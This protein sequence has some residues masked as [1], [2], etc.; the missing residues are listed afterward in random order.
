M[1]R[2]DYV[3]IGAGSAGSVLANRLTEDGQHRVL[4]LEA[5]GRDWHPY[6]HLP[7]GYGRVYYDERI[8]WKFLTA[9]VPGLGG[10]PSYWPRGKVLGGSSSINGMV[11][12]RGHPGD[13]ED[14]AEVAPGWGW[15][16]VEPAFR[17]LERWSGPPSQARGSH[18]P[19]PVSNIT[20]EVHETCRNFL[21]ASRE[22]G[23][24]E[25]ADHNGTELEGTSVYQMTTLG[26]LRASAARC[27]L[28]PAKGRKT[29]EIRT[30]AHVCGLVFE[31]NRAVGVRYRQGGHEAEVRA[32][33]SV[34]LSAGAVGS[35]QILQLSGLGPAAVL[36][37]HG[38]PLRREMPHIGQHLQDHL[39]VDY[40]YRSRVPT[41][42]QRL[43]PWIGRIAAALRFAT[44]RRGPL[45]IGVNHAG[46]FVRSDPALERPDVQLY[47]SPLSYTKAPPGTRPL[48]TPDPFPGLM[49]GHSPCRPTSEGHVN[50]AS[51][52]PEAPPDIQPAYLSTDQDRA[53][54]RAG[55]RI[56]RRIAAQ[57]SMASIIDALLSPGAEEEDDESLDAFAR[58]NGW[59]VFH[60]S[61]TCRMGH[62]PASSVVDPRLR[63]HGARGLRVV[64]ASVFPN[65]TSGNINAPTLMLA[66]RAAAMILEDAKEGHR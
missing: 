42:N 24:V 6:I 49:I 63:L 26:G 59:T 13:F 3:I 11:Y 18:G 14:W 8:N 57:P 39:G 50:I 4:L 46:G 15:E 40:I 60:P 55:I 43:R 31:D 48:L 56:M 53:V 51:S 38:V 32:S 20:A 61:C 34:I 66:E 30:H 41:L 7:I 10:K 64:D 16:D 27:W 54:M 9:P 36:A 44:S 29:L 37:A 33:R 25:I 35:P 17:K 23:F 21:D 2:F 62:D 28:T 65:I 45:T 52:D 5:G 22:A 58:D 47:Y 19:L 12:M 1:D